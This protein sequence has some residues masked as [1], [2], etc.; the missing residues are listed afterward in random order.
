MQASGWRARRALFPSE[1][2]V[3]TERA[4][5][6]NFCATPPRDSPV[7][8]CASETR[9]TR[10]SAVK[11]AAVKAV[12]GKCEMLSEGLFWRAS[13]SGPPHG[14]GLTRL[15]PHQAH[16][17]QRIRHRASRA[18]LTEGLSVI[19]D[20]RMPQAQLSLSAQ[21]RRGP[22]AR[23]T[24]RP[25]APNNTSVWLLFGKQPVH[26]MVG[27]SVLARLARGASSDSASSSSITMQLLLVCPGCADLAVTSAAP[28]VLSAREAWMAA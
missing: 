27:A 18:L 14:R 22:T 21:L 1:C 17:R 6:C 12:S 8:S 5:R 20:M 7:T 28:R 2:R 11:A 3:R 9:G 24:I 4:T 10:R 23:C 26:H 25:N 13:H 16:A 19:L 15:P